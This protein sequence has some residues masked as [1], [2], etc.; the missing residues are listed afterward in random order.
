MGVL[1]SSSGSLP[2]KADKFG[3]RGY[4]DF[5]AQ[6]CGDFSGSRTKWQECSL[7][8]LDNPQSGE[9]QESLLFVD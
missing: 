3:G 4:G 2:E 7:D 9:E 5:R 8:V 1:M 6:W